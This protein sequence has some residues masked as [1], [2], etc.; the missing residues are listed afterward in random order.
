MAKTAISYLSRPVLCA[1]S[2][3]ALTTLSTPALAQQSA[4]Q[5]ITIEAQSLDEA[6]VEVG[7]RFGVSVIVADSAARGLSAPKVSGRLTAEETIQ[8]LLVG[9]GLRY[10]RGSGRSFIIEPV[11]TSVIVVTGQQ[12]DRTLQETKESVALIT[13]ETIEERALIDFEDLLFQSANVA[14][15]GTRTT[16]VIIRGIS[17]QPF[18]IGGFGDL[19]NT[20]YD[21]VAIT[22]EAIGFISQ[23]LW[24]VDQVEILRGP[25]STNVGRNALAGAMVIRSKEPKLDTFEAV[26]RFEYGSFE[27]YA[28]EGMVN[29]PFSSETAL[30]V[31]AERSESGGFIDNVT[32]GGREDRDEFT[33]IRARFLTEFSPDLRAMV[34]LQYLDG[35][36]SDRVYQTRAGEPDDSFEARNDQPNLFSYEG[37]IG[38]LN[39]TYDVSDTWSLQS[40]TAF[41]DGDSTED[42]DPDRTEAM[43]GFVRTRT[44]QLNFSQ[45]VRASYDSGSMRGVLGGYFLRDERDSLFSIQNTFP[46]AALGI[47][48][49]LLSF[50][51][52]VLLLSQDAETGTKTTNFAFFTQWELDL[53]DKLTVSAGLRYDRESFDQITGRDRFLDP[54]TPLPN[55]NEAGALAEMM[56]PGSGDAVSAG[57]TQINGFIGNLLASSQDESSASFDALLPEFGVIYD[58]TPDV[59]ASI[60]YK[61]GYRAGG[62]RLLL[63]NT[64]NEFGPEFLDNYEAS[65][66]SEWFDKTLTVNANAYYGVWRDQQV[67]VPINGST[68]LVRTENVGSSRIWGFELETLYTPS[69]KTQLF[70]NLGYA[71]TQFRSFCSISSQVTILPECEVGGVSGRD[72]SGN[73]FAVSPDWTLAFGGQQSLTDRI[74][75]QANFTYRDGYFGNVE[76]EADV[77]VDGVFLA[78]ASV[79]YRGEWFD[80]SVYGRN[81]FDTFFQLGRFRGSV[82]G[83]FGIVPGTPREF[84][85]IMTAR[86]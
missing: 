67:N 21:D 51:P 41:S 44:N 56:Q 13:A 6:L 8:R 86:Y 33:T 55:P 7:E 66:R 78:N 77:A 29:L 85:I 3:A 48:P 15:A 10:R 68:V 84:G 12:I 54:S 40:I 82:P 60:F 53:A 30:R 19:S 47:P 65:F 71:R 45:E 46:S 4:E 17:R 36:V 28:A 57:V 70:A 27:T 16:N 72:L 59:S 73:E 64:I 9:S 52:D 25:Q 38:S 14:S 34:S 49:S 43:T 31:T 83:E 22:N 37:F 23:N 5:E 32:V 50:Y 81:L 1:L 20:F 11:E 26:T 79:A 74:S 42:S 39:L 24:D 58:F 2:A 35:D 18:A 75:V 76:N 62:A 69:D 61:R 80:V 63:D